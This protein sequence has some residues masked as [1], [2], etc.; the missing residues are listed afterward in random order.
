LDTKELLKL[1][2]DNCRRDKRVLAKMLGTSEEEVD[3]KIKELEE[4]KIILKYPALINW[5]KFDENETVTAMIDVKVTPKREVGFDDIARR[6]YRFPE[7]KSVYLM[8][9]SYD[10]SVT[11]E[12]K[13]LREIAAFV[14]EKLSALESVVSTTTHFILK[15][16]KHD[17]VIFDEGEEDRRMVVSP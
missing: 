16:Y 4:K 8:S 17:H 6:I 13:T 10:L 2:E 9:G 3:R 15:T 11:I 12:G 7:V 5:E 14:A 1:L